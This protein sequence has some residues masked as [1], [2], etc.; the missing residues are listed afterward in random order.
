MERFAHENGIYLERRK[1]SHRG[2]SDSRENR[3]QPVSTRQFREVRAINRIQGNIDAG[4]TSCSQLCGTMFEPNGVGGHG[5]WNSWHARGAPR[6]DLFEV[7]T[8][9]RFAAGESHLANTDSFDTDSDYSNDLV[10]TQKVF[11]SNGRQAFLRHA[12]RA[13]K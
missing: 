3:R 11:R 5:K 4:Q 6:D 9:Q 8:H 13:T 2:R 10:G 12:I 1:A 7:T